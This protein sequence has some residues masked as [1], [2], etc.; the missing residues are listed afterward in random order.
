MFSMRYILVMIFIPIAPLV[1]SAK[2][3]VFYEVDVGPCITLKFND[4]SGEISIQQFQNSNCN[5]S[6]LKHIGV[7]VLAVYGLLDRDYDGDFIDYQW[8]KNEVSIENNEHGLFVNH[9]LTSEEKEFLSKAIS[10]KKSFNIGY[11]GSNN[12]WTGPRFS[13]P[14]SVDGLTA[15]NI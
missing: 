4:I 2:E 11:F 10:E 14:F 1:V 8:G 13:K 9:I 7:G 5:I 12:Y 6:Y 3:F 15:A